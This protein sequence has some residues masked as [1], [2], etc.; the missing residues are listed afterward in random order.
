MLL[1]KNAET[2]SATP[3]KPS[4]TF[5]NTD[6]NPSTLWAPSAFDLLDGHRLHAVG[7]DPLDPIG[8]VLAR[9]TV[10]GHDVDPVVLARRPERLLGRRQ[11]EAG[12]AG[13]EQA[14][15]L[16]EGEH[17]DDLDLPGAAEQQDGGAVA[18]PEAVVL[19]GVAVDH[20]LVGPL[21]R[22]AVVHGGRHRLLHVS[23]ADARA[24]GH[25]WW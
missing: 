10:G 2:R 9:H 11:V 23:P 18:H 12:Q 5:W 4:S 3:A 13:T 17:P 14:V 19:G 24:T 16:A 22:P 6:R 25:R 21:R 20:D 15:G 7:Q 8:Q 1:M